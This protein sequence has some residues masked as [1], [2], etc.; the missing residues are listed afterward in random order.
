MAIWT[1]TVTNKGNALQIKQINGAKLSFTKVVTGSG[2]VSVENLK[3]QI[4]VRNIQ[5]TLSIE[6]L[7]PTPDQKKY[8]IK[9]MLSNDTLSNPYYLSQLGFYAND[10]DEGEILFAIAQL[11]NKKLIPSVSEA[12]G[13]HIEFVFTFLNEN[14]AE[15]EV[16]PDVAGLMTREETQK[17]I[18]ANVSSEI[19]LAFDIIDP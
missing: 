2:T 13:Y 19:E 1:T 3:N 16:I 10:P 17:L 15:I 11:D 5:Q 8:T 18:D 12:Y 6:G 14:G 7:T 9:V 4:D